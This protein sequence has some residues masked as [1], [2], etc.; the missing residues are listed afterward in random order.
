MVP[1]VH[2]LAAKYAENET[3]PVVLTTASWQ[4]VERELGQAASD[5]L[6]RVMTTKNLRVTEMTVI[7]WAALEGARKRKGA[8][9]VAARKL[10][11]MP[12]ML[13]EVAELI[14]DNGGALGFWAV[15]ERSSLLGQLVQES[16]V[17][18][19]PKDKD[20]TAKPDAAGP[21]T[22]TTSTGA[23]SSSPV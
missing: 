2:T 21:Q 11:P 8:E 20:D 1:A 6:Q 7:L 10:H 22:A 16:L 5:I 9:G 12:W 15:K 13:D 18:E 17:S 14:D 19:W 4:L 3:M 23:A